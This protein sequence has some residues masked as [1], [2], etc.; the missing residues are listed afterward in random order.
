MLYASQP[1]QYT[2]PSKFTAHPFEFASQLQDFFQCQTKLSM[3]HYTEQEQGI[4]F[5][6]GMQ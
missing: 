3:T 5:L 6:Q 4:M 2:T 1:T